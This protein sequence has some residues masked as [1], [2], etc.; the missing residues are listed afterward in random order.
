MW[1]EIVGLLS[2][3][4][5]AVLTALDAEGYPY[6][7]R[8][9]PRATATGRVIEVSL[10]AHTPIEAGPASLLCH[11]HDENL[12][13]LRSFLVRGALR[14]EEG[15]WAF[16]P[17]GFVPGAGVEGPMGVVRFVGGS[18]KNAERYLKKRGL[19]RPSIP[20]KRINEIKAQASGRPP[21]VASGSGRFDPL[22]WVS[23]LYLFTATVGAIVAIREG[24]PGEF[25]GRK[26]GRSVSADF[27]RGKGTA[28]SPGLPMLAAQSLLTVLSTRGGKAK[29]AGT[30]GL[31]ALGVGATVGMLGEPIA[32]RVFSHETFDP[33]K[34]ILVLSLVALPVLMTLLG[35]RRLLVR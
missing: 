7:V 1:D 14:R 15:G 29:T 35:A 24:M 13:N 4:E 34:A 20:W 5:S 26:S 21:N 3:F 8:C 22:P 19:T 12:W 16:E 17:R 32:F 18:R 10:P 11:A 27:V 23:G 28:L 30:A 2:G 9:R 6:S 31:T 33:A 25:A